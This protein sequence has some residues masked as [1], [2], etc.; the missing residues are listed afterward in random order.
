MEKNFK[1][2]FTSSKKNISVRIPEH[3]DGLLNMFI[4]LNN[5]TKSEFINEAIQN[6]I[7]GHAAYLESKKL[8]S[9][10]KFIDKNQNEKS[11]SLDAIKEL[12]FEK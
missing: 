11:L 1:I 4:K 12:I 7:Y 3:I 8:L 6:H 9:G 5:E 2:D 10:I